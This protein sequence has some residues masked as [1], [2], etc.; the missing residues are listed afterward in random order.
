MY[1]RQLVAWALGI[2]EIDPLRYDLLFERFLNPERVSLPDFD[3]DFCMNGRDDVIEYVAKRYG[4]DRVAQIITFNTLAARAVVRDVGRVMGHSYGFCDA[5][6][7]MV[8]FEVG[9]TLDKALIQSAELARR[10]K[11]DPEVKQLINN[12]KLLEGL[13]RN[14]GKHAGGLVIAPQPLTAYTAL[15]WERGMSQAVTQ[16]DKDDLE[17]LGLVKFDFLGPVSYTHL[18]LPTSALV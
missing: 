2:T 17:S 12:G 14:P 1:K 5:V 13:A 3:I 11:D 7:K 4:R 15:Y 18:P 9:M 16:F 6:A 10:C 8:P